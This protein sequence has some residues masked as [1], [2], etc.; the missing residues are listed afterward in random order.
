MARHLVANHWFLFRRREV[1]SDALL[2]VTPSRSHPARDKWV[3]GVNRQ[4]WLKQS[5]PSEILPENPKLYG[6]MILRM[7]WTG[8]KEQTGAKELVDYLSR[9]AVMVPRTIG[10]T[11]ESRSR[12]PSAPEA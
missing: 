7:R 1:R 10:I 11:P 5:L 3:G 2:P 12:Y 6:L 4:D 8:G 9:H